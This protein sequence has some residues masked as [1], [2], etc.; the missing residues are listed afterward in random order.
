MDAKLTLSLDNDVINK[1]KIFAVKN[2]ISLSRLTEFLYSKLSDKSYPNLE[3]LPIADW[4]MM[5][6]EGQAEYKTKPKSS[7]KLRSEYFDSKKSK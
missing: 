3:D 7:K 1:A 5:A 4:V 6:A 2:N